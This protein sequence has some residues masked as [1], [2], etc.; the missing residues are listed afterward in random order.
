MNT[1]SSKYDILFLIDSGIGNALE[2]LY[3]VEYCLNVG[4][5]VAIHLG[6]ISGSFQDYLSECYGDCILR[7]SPNGLKT[8]HLIHS[9]TSWDKYNIG[10]DSYFYVSSDRNSSEYMSETEM[11]ISIVR[12]LFPSDI[13]IPKTLEK[14]CD[15]YS[16]DIKKLDI[17]N[18]IVIY[19]GCHSVTSCKRWSGFEE[20]T[21][22]LGNEQ[23]IFIGGQG[24]LDF[25][26]SYTYPKFISKLFPQA[27]LSIPKFWKTLKN[28]GFLN[29]YAHSSFL[30]GNKNS[31]F[32][33]FSWKELAAI[34]SR[35]KFFIGNDGGLTHFAAVRGASGICIFG[36]TSINKNRCYNDKIKSISSKYNCQPCQ[37]SANGITMAK[38]MINCP[39]GVKCLSSIAADDV[40]KI[41][42]KD[43]ESIVD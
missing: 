28:L 2:A 42:K 38:F 23:V 20:L 43:C 21:Q 41:V 15:N 29:K 3:A 25:H 5:S 11:Y 9:F 32:D 1:T 19:P 26:F 10:Y 34:F 30:N 35:C 8:K 4:V 22:K 39:Y 14:L 17:E 37:F 31:Y 24:D 13:E 6:Y 7:K 18:K 12:T 16:D 40:F 33:V 36:P 27:I